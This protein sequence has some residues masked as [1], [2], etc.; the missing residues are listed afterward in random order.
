M[1]KEEFLNSF[2]IYL[3]S[4][5]MYVNFAHFDPTGDLLPGVLGGMFIIDVSYLLFCKICLMVF[6]SFSLLAELSQYVFILLV[7][8]LTA[9][10]LC[11]VRW[12]ESYG[13]LQSVVVG[14]L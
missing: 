3:V 11:S 12:H 13:I 10:S 4:F 2:V 9:A 14:F 7:K 5:P 8:Y 1:L 6:L